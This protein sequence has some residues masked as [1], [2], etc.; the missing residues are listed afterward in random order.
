M[1]TPVLWYSY[2]NFRFTREQI[3]WLLDNEEDFSLG[4]WPSMPDY[5]KTEIY[6]DGK[7]RPWYGSKGHYEGLFPERRVDSEGAFVQPKTIYAEVG[8]RLGKTKCD[9]DMLREQIC[10]GAGSY[11]AL[12]NSKYTY[13]KLALDWICSY[14]RRKT[15]YPQ[16]KY[17]KLGE[18]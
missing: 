2:E 5:F 1:E 16:W 11:N 6:R 9:G 13:P 8:W 12:E 17:Q 3:I 10:N 18:K 7:L 4:I 15:S 14:R